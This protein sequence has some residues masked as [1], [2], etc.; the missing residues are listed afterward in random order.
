MTINEDIKLE[1]QQAIPTHPAD[2]A[3]RARVTKSSASSRCKRLTTTPRHRKARSNRPVLPPI[4]AWAVRWASHRGPHAHQAATRTTPTWAKT[5]V[6]ATRS[7][8][9]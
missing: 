9:K 6:A 8:T 5:R 3:T 4:P 7:P 2:P 1:G